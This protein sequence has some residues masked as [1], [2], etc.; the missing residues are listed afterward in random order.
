MTILFI[1]SKAVIWHQGD[2]T[3]EDVFKINLERSVED[4]AVNFSI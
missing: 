1:V 2:E 3:L 4:D